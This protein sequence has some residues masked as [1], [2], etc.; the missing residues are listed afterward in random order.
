MRYSHALLC[1]L[2]LSL[3]AAAWPAGVVE[4]T[5]M[6]GK[7]L[8]GYQGWFRCPGDD[9]NLGWI[10]WSRG[11]QPPS[12]TTMTVDMWP[13]MTDYGPDERY[14]VPGFTYPDGTPACLFSSCN[15]R[16]VLRHFEWMRDYGIDG[17]FLQRFLVGLKGGPY[18]WYYPSVL[19]V[20][21]NVRR[22][23]RQTGRVWALSYDIAEMPEEA[24]YDVMTS[25]WKE[26][27]DR[28]LTEDP[29]YLHE[30]GKPVVQVW[31][32]YPSVPSHHITPELARRLIAFFQAPGKYQA[33]FIGGGAW[34]WRDWEDAA[35]R[36]VVEH[37]D[38]YSPWN[39]GNWARDEAGHAHA[40][41][42]WWK[43]D[44]AACNAARVDWFP[45]VYP[46]FTWD[47]LTQQPP[48]TSKIDRE[49]GRFLWEQF[50]ELSQLGVDT[51]Y[52]AMFDEVDEGTAIFK[53]T[54]SPPTQGYFVGYDGL[55][56]D[57]YLRLV[58]EGQRMLRGE[59]SVS[60]Q[61]P[62]QP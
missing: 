59:R 13:D 20:M 53:V 14:P 42:G 32:F 61:I 56:S 25:D 50:Y 38:A 24:I 58:G 3:L 55:P 7:V 43:D 52:V 5:T 34:N 46:G 41:M 35:W 19:K 28:K 16:T 27:V 30:Q 6:R 26:L 37:C 4:T 1:A 9:A 48:G 36:A 29:R 39:I 49:G 44:L 40:S 23:A 51:V 45:T 10:H 21:N 11:R 62:I 2:L 22:A 54:S 18:P 15:P 8:C 33:Y 60:R 17:V 57:W 12:A 47:N 31:G